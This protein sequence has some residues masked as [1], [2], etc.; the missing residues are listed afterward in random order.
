LENELLNSLAKANIAIIGLGLMGGSLALSLKDHCRSLS[1]FDV[2]QS[3]LKLARQKGIVKKAQGDPSEMLSEADIIILACPVAEI[4][5]WLKRLPEFI[6]QS[7]IVFDIGSSKREIIDAMDALP[8]NFDP[9]G[10]HPICGKESLS[11]LNADCSLFTDAPFILTPLKRTTETARSICFQITQ[12]IGAKAVWLDAVTH[13]K[14]LAYTS[15][16]PYLLSSSLS[17]T[18]PDI[19]KNLIGPGFRS[20]SRL[21]GTPT[22]MMMDVLMSNRDFILEALQNF[23]KYLTE[24]EILLT[25]RE[26]DKLCS[27]LDFAQKKYEFFVKK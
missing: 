18:A 9:I 21:A 1:A 13:D 15:H 20:L 10:G 27:T 19:S 23:Q 17:I 2:N 24:I 14:I 7:C 11:L 8:N 4:V 6:S 22:S 26:K 5:N 16:L 3:T 12:L 25:N